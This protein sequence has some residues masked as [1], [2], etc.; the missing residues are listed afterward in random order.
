VILMP[1]NAF[2]TLFS[3]NSN[4]V[5]QITKINGIEI[6]V[7]SI[8]TTTHQSADG[9]KES[10]PGLKEAGDVSLEG[11]LKPD[12]TNGQIAMLGDLNSGAIRSGA[13][14]FP[15]STG[16]SWQFSSYITG[17]KIGDAETEGAIP[18][19]ATI[20]ITGKPNFV[21]AT[22]VGM[23]AIALS[24]SAVISPAFAVGTFDYVATV[25]TGISSL[26]VTPTAATGVITV[27]ANGLSQTVVSGQASSAIQLGSAGSVTII[28]VT[29][30][31]NNKAAKVYTIRVVRP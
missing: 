15:A 14:N 9:Y 2:G 12:D 7:G 13:I 8:D 30:Q 4:T 26:T 18:F 10:I 11:Y 23:S 16:C 19:S 24:N 27:T 3:W 17:L 1:Y 6:K 31:E 25:L 21:T 28:T 20:K 29:V 5:A 22:S